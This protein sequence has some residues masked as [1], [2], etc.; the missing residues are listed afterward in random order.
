[1]LNTSQPI[2][3]FIKCEKQR[4]NQ[5]QVSIWELLPAQTRVGNYLT[6]SNF[7]GSIASV[8]NFSTT[9]QPTNL[10]S[11]ISSHTYQ[12]FV[13]INKE[14]ASN[15]VRPNST[16][17]GI[18]PRTIHTTNICS[19][20]HFSSGLKTFSPRRRSNQRYPHQSG[21]IGA[22]AR[23][24]CKEKKNSSIRARSVPDTKG[25]SRKKDRAREEFVTSEK[26]EAEEAQL[27]LRQTRRRRMTAR[28]EAGGRR[29]RRR[30]SLETSAAGGERAGDWEGGLARAG[31]GSVGC[32]MRE[33]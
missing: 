20:Y 21:G 13:Y 29:R 15:L 5:E 9:N 12:R 22:S 10:F 8:S 14:V 27:E 16:L 18:G 4:Y 17:Y 7:W 6:I 32:A 23:H 28:S 3:Q 33:I 19:H 24:N 11:K 26:K 1:L 30:P 25:S 2:P 31:C